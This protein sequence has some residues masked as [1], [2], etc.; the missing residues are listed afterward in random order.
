MTWGRTQPRRAPRSRWRLAVK[1]IRGGGRERDLQI[2]RTPKLVFSLKGYFL[3]PGGVLELRL[4]RFPWPP[5]SLTSIQ[6]AWRAVR[7]GEG[8]F[9]KRGVGKRSVPVMHRLGG[10]TLL[11]LLNPRSM[12]GHCTSDLPFFIKCRTFGNFY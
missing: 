9:C 6:S 12:W 4:D 5:H 2:T 1:T 10:N 7:F 8:D 11:R 3:R